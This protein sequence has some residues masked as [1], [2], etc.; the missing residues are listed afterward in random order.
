MIPATDS[1]PEPVPAPAGGPSAAGETP[2]VAEVSPPAPAT[3][4]PVK[5]HAPGEIDAAAVRR[6]WGEILERVKKRRVVWSLMQNATPRSVE[7]TELVLAVQHQGLVRR[8]ADD[9]VVRL[10]QEALHEVLGVRWTIRA[11]ADGGP[12]G[13]PGG[14]T[15]PSTGSAPRRAP[16]PQQQQQRADP[17]AER[18]PLRAVE[19]PSQA[20]QPVPAQDDEEWPAV[21]P[22]LRSVPDVPEADD[23]PLPPPPADEYGGF[24][25]GDEPEDEPAGGEADPA[26]RRDPGAEAIAVLQRTFEGARKIG[27][28]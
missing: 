13:G 23:A 14:S 25:P 11:V 8:F 18:Q 17:P 9:Q 2:P 10:L 3:P 16:E 26:P 22:V 1:A 20:A 6:L 5:T 24:D 4:E 21:R 27:D 12:G 15:T 19:A 28:V 7:G